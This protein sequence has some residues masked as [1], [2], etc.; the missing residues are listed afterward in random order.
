MKE[1]LVIK[2][3]GP[4][5]SVELELGRFNVLIG[6][7]GTGKST[8][9]K[10]LTVL[11]STFFIDLFNVTDDETI[12]RETQLFF[13]HLKLVE[14][15]NYFYD[16]TEIQYLCELY[17][18]EL[19]NKMVIIKKRREP[20]L[21]ESLY[22][23]LNYI[24]AERILVTTLANSL[25]ALIE[26]GTSLPKLFLRFGDKF[27]K[28][29]KEQ[30]SFDYTNI[31]GI[32]YIYK[33][34]KDIIILPSGKEIPTQ[35]ASSGIQGSV[36]LLT[37]FNSITGHGRIKHSHFQN[38]DKLVGYLIIEEPELSCFPETQHKLLK[39]ISKEIA[40]KED[41]GKDYY[42][43][44]LLITTHS[45]YILTSLNNMMYAYK[46]GQLYNDEADKIIEKKYWINPDDVSVYMMLPNGECEDIFDREEGMI[47]AE[48]IDEV[49]RKL[50]SQFDLLQD[51]ELG[52]NEDK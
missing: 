8:V 13:E 35:D 6:E 3:F 37:V 51:I 10:L 42:K 31:L 32:K 4:I 11:R 50:N 49:S 26:T 39:H 2:N 14:I 46:I 48:K 44:R 52:I 17:S 27:Q 9:A 36:S 38:S 5:K 22:N 40:I 7:Q 33:D 18:L 30:T 12:N 45:P 16:N 23:N 1:K 20:L 19:K 29:R 43:Y 21:E 41:F 34:N 47:K 15:Q 28:A 25:F 24:P